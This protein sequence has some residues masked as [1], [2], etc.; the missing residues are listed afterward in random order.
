M[1]HNL[2][3]LPYRPCVGMMLLNRDNKVLVAKRLD[4]IAEAWQMPQGGIDEGEAPRDALFREMEEEIGT[5]NAKIMAEYDGWL[6]YD[7]PDHLIGKLWKGKYRGQRMK[8]F[9]LR[10]LG[11][12]SDIDLHTHQPEFS[13]WKW[14]E[15][16]KVPES[17]V[18][19]KRALYT[20][21]VEFFGD[22]DIVRKTLK[23]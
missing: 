5:R 14:L 17:I 19:F 7:L 4:F 3:P 9:L 8:W 20:K 18:D 23:R 22:Q 11:E 1:T 6:S 15:M 10:Y 2:T 16:D 21:L 12:D 13:E